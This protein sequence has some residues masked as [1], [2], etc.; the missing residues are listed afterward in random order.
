MLTRALMSA[1]TIFGV[2]ATLASPASVYARTDD[3]YNQYIS[4][5]NCAVCERVQCFSGGEALCEI[6]NCNASCCWE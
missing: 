2:L 4:G 1:A 3:L 5:C 6:Q